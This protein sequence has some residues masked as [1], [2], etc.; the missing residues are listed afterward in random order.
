M[1]AETN[2]QVLPEILF[3]SSPIEPSCFQMTKKSLAQSKTLALAEVATFAEADARLTAQTAWRGLVVLVVNDKDDL[4]KTV[5]FLNAHQTRIRARKLMRVA[6]FNRIDQAKVVDILMG[7][8][9]SDIVED[10]SLSSRAFLHKIDRHLKVIEQLGAREG[11][12]AELR[13]ARIPT[14]ETV[15][16]NSEP[17]VKVVDALQLPE[18]LW[19]VQKKS[20]AKK[21]M[22]KWILEI[23]GP[24][25]AAGTWESV[26]MKGGE[27]QAWAWTSRVSIGPFATPKGRWIFFGHQPEFEWSKNR[28]RFVSER[29][30]LCF[31]EGSVLKACRFFHEPPETILI[32]NNSN[33]ALLKISYMI[34]TF[35]PEYE[36][37][38]DRSGRV[39]RVRI[40]GGQEAPVNWNV[41]LPAE[42]TSARRGE[43]NLSAPEAAREWKNGL[44]P[45]AAPAPWNNKLT[46]D[47]APDPV[48]SDFSTGAEAFKP[49]RLHAYLGGNSV[50][51]FEM[52]DPLKMD[53]PSGFPKGKKLPLRLLSENLKP[54]FDL[55]VEGVV[56]GFLQCGDRAIV[57]Y[58]ILNEA[59]KKTLTK[60]V[61]ALEKRQ[62]EAFRF[63]ELAK[64]Y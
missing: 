62:A 39:V 5:A 26:P 50:E 13:S 59:S 47:P 56:E 54:S 57:E 2:S 28:W 60:A 49:V 40:Q 14:P 45:D 46:P 20:D 19:L 6:V 53:C 25:P 30:K 1:G 32:A 12:D 18:D 34:D 33:E 27:G 29:P 8:G 21:V 48:L 37:R 7:K 23:M 38:M 31:F 15:P 17:Q 4:L 52:G 22:G 36:F 10:F 3:L 11:V 55:E 16:T 41:D 24:G 61:G 9:C 42:T 51:L 58:R 35:D 44:T 63:L 43:W 64:G